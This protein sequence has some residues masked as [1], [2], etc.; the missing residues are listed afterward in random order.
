[1]TNTFRRYV[2]GFLVVAESL[3]I[4][5]NSF[6]E[7]LQNEL[8]KKISSLPGFYKFSLSDHMIYAEY[9]KGHQKVKVGLVQDP[10]S[11]EFLKTDAK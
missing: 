8:F 2:P 9:D 3:K 5:F 11:L 7:L 10:E 4:D 1:M 6:D